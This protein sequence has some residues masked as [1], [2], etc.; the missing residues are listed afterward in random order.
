MR[1]WIGGPAVALVL[2]GWCSPAPAA[3]ST[4]VPL[5]TYG[6]GDLQSIQVA[7]DGRSF[8]TA[9]QSGAFL[10]DL[11]QGIVRHR[12]ETHG[13][14]VTA[15]AF[16]PDSRVVL[17]AGADRQI[18]GWHTD[19]GT[20]L[21]SFAGHQGEITALTFSADG[22][23][24]VSASADN[25]ARVWSLETGEA[26]PVLRVSGVFIQA[27]AFTPD[28][29]HLVTADSSPTNNVRL[30]DLATQ[31]TIHLLGEH[32]GQVNSLGWVA[33]GHLAT[34][35]DDGMVRLWDVESGTKVRSLEGD[36]DYLAGIV[37][38]GSGSRVVAGSASGRIQS[39]NTLTGE[40]EHAWTGPFLFGLGA[41]PGTDRILTANT[42]NLLR[43]RELATGVV[44]REIAGH[45]TST[46][47]GVAFSPDGRTVVSGGTEAA[48]RVWDR[49]SGQALRVLEGQAAGTATVAFTPDGQRILSTRGAPRPVAQLW[50]AA[51]G[52]L[53]REFEWT[54]G[55][56]TCAALSRDGTR[57]VT[58][59]QHQQVRVW[60]V[61]TGG[62]LRTLTGPAAWVTAV[63][64]SPDG[65][66]LASG[67]SSFA[68]VVSLW[69]ADTGQ[70]LHTFELEAGSV[71]AL[72]FSS[73]GQ[74][75]LV[76]WSDGYLRLF[77]VVSGELRRE[78]DIPTGFLNAA[79]FSPDDSL[80][81]IGEGWPTFVARLVEVESGRT[82]R[83]LP[84]HRWSVDSV[85]FN[86]AGTQVLTGSDAVR[87]WSVDD[88]AARLRVGR[89][90]GGIELK[91]NL[92]TLQQSFH[93]NGPW[94]DV[95]EAVSPWIVPADGAARFHRVWVEAE[96]N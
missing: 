46:T 51:T 38:S 42:D 50:N 58:G 83:I 33:E 94:Q 61:A 96:M 91:W 41:I 74:E 27:A 82:L 80:I 16:S 39:W 10:W 53:E 56:P 55:W 64:Y 35:G 60:N 24:F 59:A 70:S 77:D 11:E 68:P 89:L 44:V 5:R 95:P 36:A 52:E 73:T 2:G 81:L 21:R 43:E 15:L 20:E 49:A 90:P 75:L 17:T 8:A 79:V 12:F 48:I 92:G 1:N 67:G 6:L 85:A 37:V 14:R 87:L 88:L 93:V 47:L 28:G 86:A 34:A 66:R 30:W 63:A 54:T 9:G 7:P 65:T 71:T 19:S 23:R 26:G 32:V 78:Y 18:R 13:G 31:T 45:T 29:L 25:T 3:Q 22:D 84:G 69:D 62:L 72:A 76:G 40:R 4:P 57:L